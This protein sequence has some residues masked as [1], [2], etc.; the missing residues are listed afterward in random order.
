MKLYIVV[1][2]D[3]S[4]QKENSIICIRK[5]KKSAVKNLLSCRD[6]FEFDLNTQKF[7]KINK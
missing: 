2:K 1:T 4:L 6:L 5:T 3:T 7:T